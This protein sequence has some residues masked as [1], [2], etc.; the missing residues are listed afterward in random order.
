MLRPGKKWYAPRDRQYFLALEKWAG[1]LGADKVYG[2]FV[3]IYEPTGADLN[4]RIL[5]DIEEVAA[6]YGKAADDAE[7]WFT[8][9]YAGMVAEENKKNS[10]LKKR[11][12]RL[13]VHQLLLEG[14]SPAKAATLS[15]DKK[16]W[17]LDLLC[18]RRGF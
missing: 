17:M 12:K 6:T 5:S 11:I 8:V 18:E 9:L 1:S 2:D 15:R 7:L 14:L 16:W 4:P 3:R 10:Q 13:G